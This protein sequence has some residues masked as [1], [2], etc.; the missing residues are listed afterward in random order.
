MCKFKRACCWQGTVVLLSKA[1]F[2]IDLKS[3]LHS[4]AWR[5]AVSI[6]WRSTVLPQAMLLSADDCATSCC[7][8]VTADCR[9]FGRSPVPSCI[10]WWGATL[11]SLV[12]KDWPGSTFRYVHYT[13]GHLLLT[14]DQCY[15]GSSVA[16]SYELDYCCL[17]AAFAL[18]DASPCVRTYFKSGVFGCT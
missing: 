2:A 3:L 17:H 11:S 7:A 1:M 12:I 8:A 9:L 5:D 10:S 16:A 18:S 14:V 4:C 15:Y 13:N 6:H